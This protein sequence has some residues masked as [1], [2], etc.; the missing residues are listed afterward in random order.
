MTHHHRGSHP[1]ITP[2]ITPVIT[3]DHY[4]RSWPLTIARVL[5]IANTQAIA[6]STRPRFP[7]P[8]STVIQSQSTRW[9]NRHNGV[10]IGRIEGKVAMETPPSGV[11]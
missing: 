7:D 2:V 1:N 11:R 4:V 10:A 6:P 3:S 8:C 9:E 5:G